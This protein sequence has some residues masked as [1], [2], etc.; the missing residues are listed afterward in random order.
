M[1]T[2]NLNIGLFPSIYIKNF[3]HNC[4][5]LTGGQQCVRVRSFGHLFGVVTNAHSEVFENRVDRI[6]QGVDGVQGEGFLC[7]YPT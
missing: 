1:N 3:L 7:L 6:L 4:I 2:N 5:Q